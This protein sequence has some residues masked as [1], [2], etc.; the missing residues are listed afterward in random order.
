MTTNKTTDVN[1]QEMRNSFGNILIANL[2]RNIVRKM[3]NELFEHSIN[4][5]KD[6]EGCSGT[7]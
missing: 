5:E 4:E 1:A 3:E 2:I 7:L 6:R